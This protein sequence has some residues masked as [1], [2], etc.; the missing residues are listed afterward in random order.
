MCIK[1]WP[2]LLVINQWAW[3][4]HLAT[5]QKKNR[6]NDCFKKIKNKIIWNLWWIKKIKKGIPFRS[7]KSIQDS[8]RKYH[9]IRS[10]SPL[11][12]QIRLRKNLFNRIWKT[13]RRR[14]KASQL[15]L[16]KKGKKWDTL[17]SVKT[18]QIFTRYTINFGK[19]TATQKMAPFKQFKYLSRSRP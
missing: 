6:Q 5:I 3:A 2:N 12:L 7:I 19:Y 4:Y 11:L 17:E 18:H 10:P 13:K 15:L 16:K 8:H 14:S 1:Q 9:I